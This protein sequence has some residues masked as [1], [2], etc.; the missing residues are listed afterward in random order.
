[1]SKKEI[2]II[3]YGMG[4]IGS[5]YNVFNYLG[6]KVKVSG[7]PNLI[8]KSNIVILPGVGSFK[9]AMKKIKDNKIDDI[10]KDT[11]KRGNVLLGICLGMQLLGNSS[12]ED[13][14]T[15]GL[16]LVDNDVIRF[17][18]SKIKKNKIPHVGFNSVSFNTKNKLF[19]G[20]KNNSDFYFIHSYYMK[21]NKKILNS[22]TTNY[23]IEFI[24]SFAENNIY[25]TQFHPEKS[26]GNGL[27]LL[28][29]FLKII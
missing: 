21:K 18:F 15:R 25:A 14:F 2:T 29:N 17:Q 8:S 6:S 11:L 1:M 26:Q 20:L 19:S 13:G 7:D 23:G 27:K 9:K 12:T 24:S 22:S 5:L 4:N 3:D 16:S 28:D 10:I